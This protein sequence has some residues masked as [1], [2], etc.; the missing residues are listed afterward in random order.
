MLGVNPCAPPPP[1]VFFG[2][3]FKLSLDS[4][5]SDMGLSQHIPRERGGGG[6]EKSGVGLDLFFFL[7]FPFFL[8]F[9]G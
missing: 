7:P 3:G 8:L 4:L 1:P 2:G 5:M 6:L 9:S